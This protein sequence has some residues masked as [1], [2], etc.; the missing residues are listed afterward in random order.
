MLGYAFLMVAWCIS[1]QSFYTDV[2][3][4]QDYANL[5]LTLTYTGSSELAE[6]YKYL[7]PPTFFPYPILPT[8]PLP[9]GHDNKQ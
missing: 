7:E 9:M 8:I 4:M 1:F 3:A 6:Y 2:L 5:V